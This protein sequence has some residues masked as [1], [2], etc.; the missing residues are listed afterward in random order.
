MPTQARYFSGLG[1][2]RNIRTVDK[3][4]PGLFECSAAFAEN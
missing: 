3:G 1:A 2:T 4:A